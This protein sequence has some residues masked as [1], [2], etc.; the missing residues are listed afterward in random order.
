VRTIVSA[1]L[2]LATWASGQWLGEKLSLLDTFGIPAGHQSLAYNNHSRTVYLSGDKSDS[3]L[4]ID[5]DRCKSVARFPV[6]R[7]VWAMCYNPTENKLYCAYAQADTVAVLDGTSHQMLA[8]VGVGGSAGTFCFDSLDNK[9][10]V[11]NKRSATVTVLDCGDDRVVTTLN[12]V[13]RDTTWL[14]SRTC[15]AP[16]RKTVYITSPLDSSV[17]AIDCSA[18]TVL[19]RIPVGAHPEALCYNPTNDRV[20]CA[21]WGGGGAIFGIDA[22]SNQVVST[23]QQGCGGMM[24]CDPVRNVL[25]V[26]AG[27]TL[28]VVDC[29]ADTIAAEVGMPEYGAD[30]VGYDPTGD[31]VY[32][33]SGELG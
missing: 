6:G 30:L 32:L 7:G 31:K 3:I 17:V 2:L 8:K 18:D 21:C 12:G 22:A 4:V 15:F 16:A 25:F 5:A 20:Y 14:A 23:V 28:V 27:D 11:A 33:A 29:S 26:P 10:Y 1:V 19:A 24:A 13:H 9:M